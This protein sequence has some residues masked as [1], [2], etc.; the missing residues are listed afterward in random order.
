[1]GFKADTAVEALDWDFTKYGAGSGTSPGPSTNQIERYQRRLRGLVQAL[2]RLQLAKASAHT[3]LTDEQLRAQ[4]DEWVRMNLDEA[5]AA[6]DQ[7]QQDA[8][9]E[10]GAAGNQTVLDAKI[11]E[12]VAETLGNCPNV[13]QI[14][15]LPH[16]VRFAFY[17]WVT[18]ELLSPELEAADS[19][20]SLSLVRNG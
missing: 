14:Q 18:Q 16:R 13:E 10:L 19:K 4:M 9:D 11:C 1:M 20:P 2:Q 6:I 15:A 7:E 8:L 3:E 12:L 17:G 5:I